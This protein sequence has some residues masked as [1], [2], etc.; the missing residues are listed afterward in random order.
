MSNNSVWETKN[1]AQAPV[2]SGLYVYA[3]H[4]D[5][6]TNP[7][8]SLRTGHQTVTEKAIILH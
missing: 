4:V 7:S 2:A 1:M 3:L 6:G 5:D 8:T